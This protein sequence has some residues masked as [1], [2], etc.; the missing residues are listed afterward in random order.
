MKLSTRQLDAL[1]ELVN[2]GIG[3]AA[4]VLNDMIDSPIR[5]QIPYLQILTPIDVEEELEQ[6]LNGEQ[7]AAV[8]LKFTGSFGGI[9]QLVFPT[10]SAALLVTMLTGEEVG[11]HDLD[12]VKIGTLSEVGNIVINGVMGAISNVLQQRLNYSIPTYSEGTIAN[13][14]ISGGLATDTVVLLAQTSFMIE[15]LH[16]EGDIILIFNVNSFDTLLTAINQLAGG[17]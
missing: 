13:L 3:Q 10:N 9:A 15:R 11:T 16:I 1:Q 8:Q 6:H 2:I 7:I 12:S 17:L 4:G 5:L 14:L